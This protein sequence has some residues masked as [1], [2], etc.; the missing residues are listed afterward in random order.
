MSGFKTRLYFEFGALPE[1][2]SQV[3][4][5]GAR[6]SVF[7][8]RDWFQTF[9][10]HIPADPRLLRIYGVEDENGRAAALLPLMQVPAANR[11]VSPTSLESLSN[12]YTCYFAPVLRN[13]DEAP[14]IANAVARGLW[15]D[16]RD[17]DVVKLQP[18]N[19]ES[20][21]YP[22]L[23]KA[24]RDCG[25]VVQTYFCFGNWYLEVAGRTYQE[26]VDGLSSVL[27]KNIPYNLRRLE[28][29]G[30]RIEIVTDE[31][32]LDRSIDDYET[33]YNSSWKTHEATPKFIREMARAAAMNGWL[34]LGLLYVDGEPA[35]AQLWIVNEGV[36]SI[37]KVA[38]DERFAKL[39]AGTA[40]TAKLMQHAIDVD[41]VTIVDYLSGEDEYKKDWMSHRREFWGIVA[42]NPRSI[43]GLAQI[44][45]HVGGAAAKRVI[46]RLAA[47]RGP[48]S[49]VQ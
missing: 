36:A 4:Q 44:A 25:M 45:R 32:G 17:W 41:K 12:Y 5:S 11:L 34:R 35:A 49:T 30:G 48:R 16:R 14:E 46:Q 18:L 10:E 1:S 40:L 21:V 29:S 33:V 8:T 6:V 20:Q 31:A 26:Y 37:Y 43:H 39:S 47:R 23:V 2:Y 24:F 38:Y 22:A 15:Q 28:K 9:S 3:F 42:F 27:R 13:S 7:L 19:R